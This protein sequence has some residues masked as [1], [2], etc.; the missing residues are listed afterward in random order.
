[1]DNLHTTTP[2]TDAGTHGTH[3]LRGDQTQP[4]SLSEAFTLVAQVAREDERGQLYDLATEA[5]QINRFRAAFTQARG[6][7]VELE[8]D[9]ETHVSNEV[10]RLHRELACITNRGRNQ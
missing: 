3:A 4:L 1:M 5:A 7:L 2:A 10:D 8:S 9:F 6:Q